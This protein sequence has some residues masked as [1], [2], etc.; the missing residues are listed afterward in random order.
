M[1][2]LSYRDKMKVVYFLYRKG[3]VGA[4]T[5]MGGIKLSESCVLVPSNKG[6][7]IVSILNSFGADAKKLKIYV[8]EDILNHGTV[9]ASNSS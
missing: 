7:E 3:G 9:R 4:I 8:S 6:D 2:S 5:K 1:S